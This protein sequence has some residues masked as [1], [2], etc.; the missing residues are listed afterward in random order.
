MS[1]EQTVL[2]VIQVAFLV[3]GS[4]KLLGEA[5]ALMATRGK[6]PL[7]GVSRQRR[8]SWM[9]VSLVLGMAIL[10]ISE[11]ATRSGLILLLSSIAA[12][13]FVL[14]ATLLSRRQ[15]GTY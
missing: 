15:R 1:I 3:I 4:V 5:R 11:I 2:I 9:T 14:I 6:G 7:A 12:A 10:V 8:K 13:V